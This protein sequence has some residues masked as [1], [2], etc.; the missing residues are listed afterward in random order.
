METF[1]PISSDIYYLHNKKSDRTFENERFADSKEEPRHLEGTL[2]IVVAQ[3][4]APIR[5]RRFVAISEL[6]QPIPEFFL[7]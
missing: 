3:E 4:L 5:R 6:T 7:S 2:P 1:F